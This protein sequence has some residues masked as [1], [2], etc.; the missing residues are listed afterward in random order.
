MKLSAL[1]QHYNAARRS[2]SF[3]GGGG[4]APVDGS[5]ATA[6]GEPPFSF[7]KASPAA[8][9]WLLLHGLCCLVSL[10]LGFRFSRLVFFLLFSNPSSTSPSSS[11]AA[12]LPRHH[13]TVV[14]SLDPSPPPPLAAMPNHTTVGGAV[15]GGGG[16][17]R[18]VVGRHGIRIRPWPHPNAE[19]VM[20][21]HRI[22]ERVQ[23][24]QRAQ[25]GVRS[26]RPVIAV[27]PTYSRTFQALHLSGVMH[28]LMLVPYDLTWIV[29]EAGGA[30]T[31]ET[32]TLLA[33]S[34]LRTIHVPFPGGMPVEWAE[35]HRT[36]ARMRLHALR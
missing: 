34:G 1:Q 31:D 22:L 21:A 23:R 3:R 26:P 8:A 4:P 20:R 13:A 17:S 36:E 30:A 35:R 9:F 7:A 27:T 5:A 28:S 25:Y 2:N 16:G 10:V 32:T 24:E 15:A 33:R 11:N 29:V 18:V 12:V 14:L 6:I 19:E